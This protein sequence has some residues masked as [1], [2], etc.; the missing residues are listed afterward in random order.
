[1]DIDFT[2]TRCGNCCKNFKV[3]LT[4]DEAE[5]WLGDGHP[6]QVL[7]EAIPWLE[8]PSSSNQYALYKRDRS[9]FAVS[10]K[11]PMRI[12]VTLVAPL[13]DRCP[14][15]TEDGACGIYE[16]RPLVC[17]IYPAESNPFLEI[18]PENRRCSP[19]AWRAGAPPLNDSERSLYIQAVRAHAVGD[20]LSHKGL[21]GALGIDTAAML[22]EGYVVYS[23]DPLM[24]LY[25]LELGKK[26]IGP[27]SQNWSLVSERS[28][29]VEEIRSCNGECLLLSEHQSNAY[30]YLSLL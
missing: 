25:A 20:V 30:E 29:V 10:G 26:R 2:C 9:F 7:C 6:V 27:A 28:Q 17:R 5:R 14:N 21:C 13:G 23:P 11:L 15:L 16:R 3:P 1:M 24:L 18:K 12:Q 22:N 8:E 19:D 4:L